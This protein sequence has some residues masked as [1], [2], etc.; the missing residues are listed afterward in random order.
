[1]M[2]DGA[3]PVAIAWLVAP[4]AGLLAKALSRYPEQAGK[5]GT[6][7]GTF[8]AVATLAV[9]CS[10]MR[11]GTTLAPA[12][13]TKSNKKLMDAF[14]MSQCAYNCFAERMLVCK[15]LDTTCR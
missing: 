11:R 13:N 15:C 12:D 5:L 3:C 9:S 1:M 6:P 8:V 4:T 7:C 14:I 10:I 2:S